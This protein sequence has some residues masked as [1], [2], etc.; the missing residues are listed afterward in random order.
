MGSCYERKERSAEELHGCILLP[1]AKTHRCSP[2]L[3]HGW[4]LAVSDTLGAA[5]QLTKDL[6]ENSCSYLLKRAGDLLAFLRG[7]YGRNLARSA[8]LYEGLG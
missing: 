2:R 5:C 4:S 3:L 6:R 1:M 7:Q 8:L